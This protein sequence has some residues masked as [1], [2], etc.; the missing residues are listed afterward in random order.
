MKSSS[1]MVAG[2]A[3]KTIAY[4]LNIDPRTVEIHRANVMAKMQARSLPELVRMAIAM[5][6][7]DEHG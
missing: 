5:N 6:L 1:G 2:L 4:D 7:L 3:N